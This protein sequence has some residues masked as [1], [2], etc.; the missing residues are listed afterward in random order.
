MVY[1]PTLSFSVLSSKIPNPSA[2]FLNIGYGTFFKMRTDNG[3]WR[4][5]SLY[6]ISFSAAKIALET[7]SFLYVTT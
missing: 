1:S 5:G 3:L 6:L 7:K 2:L 4:L